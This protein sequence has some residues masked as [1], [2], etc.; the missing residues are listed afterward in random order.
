MHQDLDIELDP[1]TRELRGSVEIRLEGSGLARLTLG[2]GFTVEELVLDDETIATPPAQEQGTQLWPLALNGGGRHRLVVRYRGRLEP[3]PETDHRG[4]L[5]ALPPMASSEGSYLPAGSGWYPQLAEH[6]FTYRLRLRLPPGQRG[7][8][9]GRL[10]AEE[11]DATGYRAQYQFSHPAEGIELMAGPYEVRERMLQRPGAP[12]VR[13]RTWFHP[14]LR[15]VADEYLDAVQ[16]YIRLY[17]DW[18]GAYPFDEFSV[19]S[20][21]LPTGFGMP[22]FTYLGVDVL[23]LPFIKSTSLGHEVLHNWWGNGVYLD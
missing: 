4:T 5:Q 16:G 2:T 17:S 8:V 18:I 1:D 19:V 20:S 3:L 14:Q 11:A 21:P 22:T 12:P 13:V 23:R 9:P 7:L 6:Y 10:V 15:D